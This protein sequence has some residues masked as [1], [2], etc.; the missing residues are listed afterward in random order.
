MVLWFIEEKLN[1]DFKH[2][3]FVNSEVKTTIFL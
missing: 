3:R 1:S 2:K